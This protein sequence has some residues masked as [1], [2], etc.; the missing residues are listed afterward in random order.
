[1][2]RLFVTLIFFTDKLKLLWAQKLLIYEKEEE[3][4]RSKLKHD[5]DTNKVEDSAMEKQAASNLK[6]WRK[7]LF[8]E[9]TAAP[10]MDFN[11]DIA[12]FV[13]VR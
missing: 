9:A 1:M 2:L 4:L 8:G 12:R 5:S 7:V 11:G 3:D 13:A 6:K 10:Q